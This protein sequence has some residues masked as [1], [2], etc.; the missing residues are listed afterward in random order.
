MA[1][2]FEKASEEKGGAERREAVRRTVRAHAMVLLPGLPGRLGR[3]VDVSETGVCVALPEA[4]PSGTE[5]L[6]AFELPD[7]AGN[8]RRLQSKAR[9]V[10]SV[11]SNQGD[12][13]KVG[14]QL[15]EPTEEVVLA[16]QT[17]VRE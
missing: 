2:P 6:V 4:L 12:G 3:T 7:K 8:R 13:F 17:F 5:C 16:L 15:R 1:N 11:L 9:V 10:H 14:M